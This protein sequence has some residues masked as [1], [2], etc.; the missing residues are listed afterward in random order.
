MRRSLQRLLTIACALALLTAF[1]AACSD[2]GDSDASSDDTGSDGT[3]STSSGGSIGGEALV[4]NGQGND[5]DVYS[6]EPPFEAQKLFTNAQDDPSAPVRAG[7]TLEGKRAAR[8]GYALFAGEQQVGEITSGAF[9]PTLEKPIALAYVA[10]EF[11]KA[12]THLEVEIRGRRE[13]A[14]VVKLPFYRRKKA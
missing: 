8:Q 13:T 11:T 4:F 12:G 10:P 14:V 9:S 2:D 5:L 1:A 6:S 7:L 3:T